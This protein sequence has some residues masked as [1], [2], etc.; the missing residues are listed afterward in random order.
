VRKIVNQFQQYIIRPCAAIGWI[1]FV[2]GF[3][4]TR[5]SY[6]HGEL[7]IRIAEVTGQIKGATNKTAQLYLERAELYRMDENWAAAES[8][9]RR[10]ELLSPMTPSIQVCHAGMLNDSGQL[11]MA[12]AMVDAV[13][14]HTSN[15]GEAFVGRARVLVKLGQR[16]AAIADFRRGLELLADPAAENFL[17]FA[18]SLKAGGETNEALRTLDRGI[19]K[20]GPITSLQNPAIEFELSRKNYDGALARINSVLPELLRKENWL[21]RRGDILTEAGRTAEA[22]KSYQEALG[23]IK[24]LPSRIQQSSPMQNLKAHVEGALGGV[25]NP[26]IAGK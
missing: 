3:F 17:E 10:A 5:S 20:L 19:K 14:E 7:L 8:D 25:E 18:E 2:V 26:A 22:H 12:R 21:A 23:A 11:E 15:C 9:Y 24:K 16:T 1:V 4:I 13:L 6:A